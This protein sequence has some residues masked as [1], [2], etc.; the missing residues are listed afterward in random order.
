[1]QLMY[2]LNIEQESK[3]TTRELANQQD[4]GTSTLANIKCAG[5]SDQLCPV[6]AN[7]SAAERKFIVRNASPMH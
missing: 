1:M 5:E 7:V 6:Y 3:L 4:C 2:V